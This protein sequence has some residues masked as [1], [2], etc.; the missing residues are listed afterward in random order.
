MKIGLLNMPLDNNYGGN[1][2]R[3]A[4]ITV[5]QRMGHQAVL[6]AVPSLLPTYLLFI[7]SYWL[8]NKA[9]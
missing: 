2:Q 5:L 1:L 8:N 3:Y 4:L 7:I 6:S 9:T